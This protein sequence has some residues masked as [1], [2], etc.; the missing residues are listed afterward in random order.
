MEYKERFNVAKKLNIETQEKVR[1]SL[2]EV[3]DEKEADFL[4]TD[5][6]KK[7]EQEI[8]KEI[9]HKVEERCWWLSEKWKEKGLP[10]EQIE[11]KIG[12]N[13]IEVYNFNREVEFSDKHLEETVH[14][15]KKYEEYDPELLK[16]IKFILINN[17]QEPSLLDNEEKFPLN[18]RHT[19]EQN[20]I[21][22]FPRG[23]RLDIEHRIPGISNFKGTMAHE[24]YHH[25]VDAD[26]VNDWRENF[27]WDWCHNYPDDWLVKETKSGRK[28]RLNKKT[29]RLNFSSFTNSPE[30]CL[31]DY[32]QSDIDEDIC[33]SAVATFFNP[34]FIKNVSIEKYNKIKSFSKAKETV[35]AKEIPINFTRIPPDKIKLPELPQK[36]FTFYKEKD[37]HE[38]EHVGTSSLNN[39]K[40]KM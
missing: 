34:E 15:L 27:D 5:S 4:I 35:G 13:K 36:E 8:Y 17:V 24:T 2:H 20:M 38:E 37:P 18:G 14:I 1:I 21:E 9:R 7:N 23:M 31:N 39:D 26:I 29:G 22:L 25:K 12:D 19:K 3:F 33:D 40:I 32:A 6:D 30:L 10:K 28:F 11:I 16:K